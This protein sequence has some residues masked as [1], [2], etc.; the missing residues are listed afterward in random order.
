MTRRL[1]VTALALVTMMLVAGG[2]AA[3]SNGTAGS[4][5]LDVFGIGV[6]AGPSAISAYTAAP[7]GLWSLTYNPA[8]L[9]GMTRMGIG[10]SQIEWIADANYSYLSMGMPAGDGGMALGLSYF[11]KGSVDVTDPFGTWDPDGDAK[12]YDFGF[13]GGYGFCLPQVCDLDLGL[14]GYL[15][16]SSLDDESSSVIGVNLGAL[17]HAMERQ[18]HLGLAVRNLGTKVSFGDEEY[19]QEMTFA[20]G[21]SYTTM[22]EQIPNVDVMVGLDALMPKDQDMY[23]SVGGEFW[24]YQTLALRA[25]YSGAPDMGGLT[26]GAG[27]KFSDF[28]LDYAYSDYEDL[29][30]THRISLS[31]MFGN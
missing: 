6:G 28:G 9:S 20:G 26:Y 2:A 22:E 19:D 24:V 8:A 11:D 14:S 10:V 15:V 7:G 13:V 4:T 27:F 18:V 25:G 1:G 30:A 17:Y 16:Q 12:A 29:E 23:V 31:V 21:I 5:Y 3:S